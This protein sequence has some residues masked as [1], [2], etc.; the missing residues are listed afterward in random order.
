MK[1]IIKYF[2]SLIIFP[3][4]V[5]SCIFSD[6][7][8][9]NPEWL[10]NLILKFETEP[11]G[12]PPQSIWQYEYKNEIVYFVPPQCC[13][14][15]STLYTKDGEFICAPDGGITGDG[16]GTCSDFF[17]ESKEAKLVWKDMRER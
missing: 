16:D 4:V 12:N 13:D 14:E 15:F 7:S 2:V 5:S 9:E 11:V 6:S 8:D 10:Q 1:S 3:I 17:Q